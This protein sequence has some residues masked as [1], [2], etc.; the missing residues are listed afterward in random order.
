MAPTSASATPGFIASFRA[1]GDSLLATVHD[2]QAFRGR[3]R[4]EKFRLIRPRLIGA[5][6]FTGM[7]AITF[8]SLTAGLSFW[9]SARLAV[10]GGLAILTPGPGRDHHRVSPLHRPPAEPVLGHVARNRGRPRMYPQREL[11]R[12]AAYKS[13]LRRDVALR[14]A[15][16]AGAAA[17]MAQP[18]EWLD[19]MLVFWRRLSPLAQ[20]ATVPLGLLVARTV[21]PRL[22]ILGSLARWGP[23]VF[24]AVRGLSSVVKTR[25]WSSP[26][27]NDQS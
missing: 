24:G 25:F 8:A 2:R 11:I 21:F 26:S 15:Q 20:F 16:C 23:L 7:L 12:L 27:S 19:R 17:R 18:V 22:K 9:E 10:L 6:V 5:A 1:L 4:E 3:L 13:A 14:R